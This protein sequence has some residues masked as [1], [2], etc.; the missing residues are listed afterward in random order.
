MKMAEAAVANLEDLKNNF[1]SAG[2]AYEE[3]KKTLAEQKAQEM[4][5]L[6]EQFDASTEVVVT[7]LNT[8]SLQLEVASTKGSSKG[9]QIIG[10]F[11]GAD[12]KLNELS[13]DLASTLGSTVA[14]GGLIGLMPMVTMAGAARGVYKKIVN[15]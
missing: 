7:A 12:S 8:L 13:K 14:A 6:K 2:K 10:D 4:N 11:G 3:A 9:K 15:A 5:I 1:A